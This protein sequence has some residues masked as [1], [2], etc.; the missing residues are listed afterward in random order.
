M[1][2]AAKNFNDSILKD[3]PKPT[4]YIEEDGDVNFEWYL[5]PRH[6]LSVSVSSDNFVY[7]A[8]LFGNDSLKDSELFDG[9]FP[10]TL[11]KII[12]CRF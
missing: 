3:L 4:S 6:I 8:G 11:F 1:N 2:I 9:K 7:Y 12:K 10:E 5:N